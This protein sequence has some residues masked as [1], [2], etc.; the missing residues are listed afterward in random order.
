MNKAVMLLAEGD[1]SVWLVAIL[2]VTVVF[3]GLVA[4]VGLVWVMNKL[5]DRFLQKKPAAAAP[6]TPAAPVANALIENRGEI[7]AAVCAAVAEEE[8]V[9]ISALRVLSFKK[10]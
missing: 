5:C 2:G 3:V 1:P 4:I 6:V 8:G 10:L 7:V 9:D